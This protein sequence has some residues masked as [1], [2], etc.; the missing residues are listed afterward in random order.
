MIQRKQKFWKWLWALATISVVSAQGPDITP[1]T[2]LLVA[3][4]HD[5]TA[6]AKQ[7]LEQGADPNEG[8]LAGLFPPVFL[9]ITHQQLDLLR[10]MVAKGADLKARDASGSTALMWAAANE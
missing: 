6:A 9:A 10:V 7:L 2:P 3:L 4:L 5:D 1:R 8:R